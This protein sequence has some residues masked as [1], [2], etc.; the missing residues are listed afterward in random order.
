MSNLQIFAITDPSRMADIRMRR[1]RAVFLL[2]AIVLIPCWWF[3]GDD[4][5]DSSRHQHRSDSNGINIDIDDSQIESAVSQAMGSLA[6]ILGQLKLADHA[7]IRG[8][9]PPSGLGPQTVAAGALSISGSC[10]GKLTIMPQAGLSG[11]VR[12]Y[13]RHALPN[14]SGGEGRTLNLNPC[15]GNSDQDVYLSVPAGMKLMVNSSGDGELVIG[16]MDGDVS[17]TRGGDGKLTITS[18]RHLRLELTSDGDAS[19]AIVDGDAVINRSG[20]GSLTIGDSRG[21]LRI[22]A[23]GDGDISLGVVAATTVLSQ[24]GSGDVKIG[25]LSGP[26]RLD[27]A[28]DGDLHVGLVHTDALGVAMSGSGSLR[29]GPGE[30]GVF[31]ASLAGS[32]DGEVSAHVGTS[33][34][35]LSH[36]ATLTLRHGADGSTMVPLPP[37]PPLPP[38]HP[39][40][41]G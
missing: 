18:A 29:I 1:R 9:A 13:A 2:A 35:T 24:R 32:V 41:P 11:Q 5:S 39:L 8:A 27:I 16:G 6:S 40:P 31:D 17:V 12:I 38:L 33:R 4:R 20:S 25:T 14:L 23:S 28:G 19:V 34:Q 7:R 21:D 22:N 36:D 26:A 15:S 30:I 3:S 37:L 10:D